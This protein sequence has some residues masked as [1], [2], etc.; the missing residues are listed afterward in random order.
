MKPALRPAFLLICFLLAHPFFVRAAD[1]FDN[2]YFGNDANFLLINLNSSVGGDNAVVFGPGGLSFG[3]YY[4][5]IPNTNNINSSSNQGTIS[6]FLIKN[7]TVSL[8]SAYVDRVVSTTFYYQI[9]LASQLQQPLWSTIILSPNSTLADICLQTTTDNIFS[10]TPDN[11]ILVGL[12]AGDYILEFYT[13]SELFDAGKETN[14][15][16][17]FAP[18]LCDATETHPDRYISSTFNTTDPSA[19]TLASTL[20]NQALPTK[21]SFHFNGPLPLELTYFHG[22]LRAKNVQLDWQTAQEQD[23]ADFLIER[24]ADGFNW[25]PLAE[26]H[27]VGNS[28]TRH[29]YTFL[30]EQTLKGLNYYRLKARSLDGSGDISPTVVVAA[31]V[32]AERLPIWPNPVQET[33][34]SSLPGDKEDDLELRVLNN[35][36]QV[37]ALLA[38]TGDTH[39]QLP[40][41]QLTEGV[42]FLELHDTSGRRLAWTRFVKVR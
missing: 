9:H 15:C 31:S 36:G 5:T 35:N 20:A 16:N 11:N 39:F 34:Y 42:Y 6:S 33:L 37:V 38:A 24:S 19:C 28:H 30:D 22:K 12:A 4:I 7:I 18:D 14:P 26:V 3:G 23:L 40:T 25:S 17:I 1:G 10:S 13:R 8:R 2:N 41:G 32:G 29:D 27:A 21:I